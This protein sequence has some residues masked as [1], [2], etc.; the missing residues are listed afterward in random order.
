MPRKAGLGED[1]VGGDNDDHD[2]E[3]NLALK[4]EPGRGS[5]V[6]RPRPPS[7]PRR[8]STLSQHLTSN[9]HS[10]S[11]RQMTSSRQ[12]SALKLTICELPTCNPVSHLVIVDLVNMGEINLKLG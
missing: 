2:Y 5:R 8:Q 4:S 11:S 3:E 6:R 9:Q 7:F 1:D 10:T 12:S